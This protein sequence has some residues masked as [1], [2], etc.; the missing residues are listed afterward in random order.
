VGAGGNNPMAKVSAYRFLRRKQAL[1]SEHV[2]ILI[3]DV[4]GFS[5]RISFKDGRQ[6]LFNREQLL[7]AIDKEQKIADEELL[8]TEK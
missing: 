1:R 4:T 5:L 8:P 2:D 6:Y 7:A 3:E